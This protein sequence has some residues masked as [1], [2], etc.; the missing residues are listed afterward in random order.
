MNT[1]PENARAALAGGPTLELN[2]T[3]SSHHASERASAIAVMADDNILTL[4]E[5]ARLIALEKTIAATLD[6]FIEC[7]NALA[8]IRD[9]KLYRIEH[10]TFEDYCRE[11]WNISRVH[12]HRLTAAAETVKML[13]MG[14]KPKSERQARP[15]ARL[16]EEKRAEAWQ[17]AVEA[18]P[19]GRP[20]A[21]EVEV[22]AAEVLPPQQPDR[23]NI[24]KIS[25][26]TPDIAMQ[27]VGN[28]IAVM[29][30]IHPK[31]K[32]REKS[33]QTMIEH[34]QARLGTKGAG[35][36]TNKFA[37]EQL[38][39]GEKKTRGSYA[40]WQQ[41]RQTC[42]DIANLCESLES[43]KVDAAHAIPA[44][45]LSARLAKKLNKISCN[46]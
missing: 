32:S 3:S 5:S 38:P 9:S 16:P 29:G 42:A 6:S 20:T 12:A 21:R 34:C 41:F 35:G 18:S 13:P 26:Y 22:A 15:L 19:T 37:G 27:I 10:K 2:A 30:T 23:A 1:P 11:K 43:L 44:R 25:K 45:D 14:N 36:A 40:D 4:E 46:Q 7:G 17:K 24:R 39:P 28:A 31:D 8:E 33:L